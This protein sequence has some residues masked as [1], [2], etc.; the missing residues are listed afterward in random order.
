MFH[1]YWCIRKRWSSSTMLYNNNTIAHN[2]HTHNGINVFWLSTSAC[3]V[4]NHES[5][6]RGPTFVTRKITR[7]VCRIKRK[8]QDCLFLGNLDAKRDWGHA[9][10]YVEGMWRKWLSF[11]EDNWYVYVFMVIFM[12]RAMAISLFCCSAVVTLGSDGLLLP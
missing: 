8:K 6:R 3:T 1:Y 11:L 5:P 7:A 4:V 12:L 9:K 2:H 10:D